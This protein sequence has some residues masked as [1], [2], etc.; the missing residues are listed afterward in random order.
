MYN[1]ITKADEFKML[2]NL[3]C[4]FPINTRADGHRADTVLRQ[5][6]IGAA[7]YYLRQLWF[8][9]LPAGQPDVLPV[10]GG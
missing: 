10:F 1:E 5:K 7:P 6:Q 9:D 3:H 4:K 2:A 8:R